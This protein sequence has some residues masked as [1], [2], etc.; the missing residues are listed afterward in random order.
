VNLPFFRK[1][2]PTSKSIQY[3]LDDD[4]LKETRFVQRE[5]KIYVLYPGIL[6]EDFDETAVEEAPAAAQS[7]PVRRLLSS[8]KNFVSFVDYG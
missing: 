6:Q 4:P 7:R 8:N 2:H 3:H 1:S 5:T